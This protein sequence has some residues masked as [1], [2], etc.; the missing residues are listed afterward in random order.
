[1]KPIYKD[2]RNACIMK[3][4]KIR[5]P[6]AP[7][8][9]KRETWE[10]YCKRYDEW[11]AV[12]AS[13]NPTGYGPNSDLEG[14]RQRLTGKIITSP[15]DKYAA[16]MI[17]PF[18]DRPSVKCNAAGLAWLD[19][20]QKPDQD[21]PKTCPYLDD[22]PCTYGNPNPARQVATV[23]ATKAKPTLQLHLF[24]QPQWKLIYNPCCVEGTYRL[25]SKLRKMGYDVTTELGKSDDTI[26]EYEILFG[27]KPC[28]K[29]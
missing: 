23:I 5:R 16:D 24:D 1:M 3:Q 26:Q 15:G 25:N 27:L 8:K 21:G 13:P 17:S 9:R 7:Q 14:M 28:Y 20:G 19:R 2:A 12:Y 4:R 10:R 29:E 22:T 11:A 6:R 18:E